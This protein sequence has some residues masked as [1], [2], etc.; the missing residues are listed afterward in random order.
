MTAHPRRTSLAAE[1]RTVRAGLAVG[2]IALALA[3]CDSPTPQAPVGADQ[4]ALERAHA[5]HAGH[6]SGADNPGPDV[7]AEGELLRQVNELRAALGPYHQVKHAEAA[8]YVGITGCMVKPGVGGMGFHY[9][10]VPFDGALD[11]T[12]P[13]LLVY[14]PAGESGKNVRLVAVEWAVPYTVWP[15]E[16]APPT[17]MGLPLHHNDDFQ[18]WVLHAWAWENNPAGMFKDWNPRISC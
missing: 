8:G 3:G 11:H 14:A 7:K 15:R 5:K 16:S 2:A 12:S 10:K 17:V 4:V 18:L 9:G 1:L 6:M 13:E